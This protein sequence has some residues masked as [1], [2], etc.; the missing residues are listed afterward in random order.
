MEQMTQLIESLPI[1]AAYFEDGVVRPNRRLL[2]LTGHAA[3]EFSAPDAWLG[4]LFCDR[5]DVIRLQ[6]ESDRHLGF[7]APRHCALNSKEHGDIPVEWSSSITGNGELW[8]FHRVRAASEIPIASYGMTQEEVGDMLYWVDE[9][10]YIRSVNTVA[11]E[12][13]GYSPEEM[14]TKNVADIDPN[15]TIEGWGRLWTRLKEKKRARFETAHRKKSGE[16]I[17]VDIL[18]Q[19]T[20]LGGVEY[21]C[22]TVRDITETKRRSAEL[23]HDLR[24]RESLLANLLGMAYRSRCDA[25]WTF[26]YASSGSLQLTGYA[27]ERFLGPDAIPFARIVHPDDLGQLRAECCRGAASQTPY[28]SEYRIIC[29]DG[30]VK[31]VLDL[32]RSIYNA[33]GVSIAAEGFI[34]DITGRKRAEEALRE[35][36]MLFSSFMDNSPAIAFMKDEDG[37]WIYLNRTFSQAIWNDDP[38]EWRGKYDHELWHP[39]SARQFREHDAQVLKEDRAIQFDEVFFNAQ[40]EDHYISV[41]FP[42][43]TPDGKRFLAG[44]AM[45]V[46]EQRAEQDAKRHMEAQLL[47]MQKLES[48]G[49]LAGG[50]AHDFNNL[51]TGIMGHADLAQFD[52]PEDSA[53]ARSIAQISKAARRAADL[54]RQMLAYSGKGAFVVTPFD[55][56]Q[57]LREMGGLLDLAISKRC[58]IVYE[59]PSGLPTIEGDPT[60]VRQVLM[61]LI[62]NASEAIG[63]NDGV[64]RISAG[65]T[66]CSRDVLRA[67]YLDEGLPAGQYVYVEVADSGC[68]MDEETR[69]RLFDPFFTTKFAGR[70]LGMAAVLG[71]VRGHRAAITVE[72]KQGEGSKFR[73]YFPA[74]AKPPQAEQGPPLFV[75][76]RFE[77]TILVVDDEATV[78]QLAQEMLGKIGFK[79]LIANDGLEGVELYKRHKADIR[80][81]LL[82]AT[83]PKLDGPQTLQALR[84]ITPDLRIVLSSGYSESD[85]AARCGEHRP[86]A[87]IE[88]PYTI[89]KLVQ[90]LSSLGQFRD[91]PA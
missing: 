77:G 35:S 49:V 56:S 31:W 14:L 67:A 18:S 42:L 52:V 85:M 79:V 83:M 11:C 78:R 50:I 62:I 13:I 9:E 76:A 84:A 33:A 70:G 20:V 61:N 68:G 66:Y 71:I 43:H 46:T 44:L 5:A 4:L 75:N 72:S 16:V 1:A 54:T 88:K 57:A 23:E 60:Q 27:P 81:V 47:H 29:A 38:P 73:V 24:A 45:N 87:F 89:G 22:S 15:F 74:S 37:R 25:E 19:F 8:L 26:E 80:V 34:T 12:A 36:Q 2:A 58:R 41:K 21:A 69:L 53:A 86:D 65:S 28:S 30:T 51:L 48:L 39:D 59:L 17:Q 10:G 6:H 3:G 7:P 40:R 82:D 90:V 55:L 63:E 32:A 91:P 64:I